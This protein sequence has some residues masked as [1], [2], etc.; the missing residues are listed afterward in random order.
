MGNVSLPFQY[1]VYGGGLRGYAGYA[2]D[3]EEN[4]IV[5]LNG[6]APTGLGVYHGTWMMAADLTTGQ[7]LWNRTYEETRYSTAAFVLTTD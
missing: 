1:A 7:M 4:V 6:I 5:V 2:V 3:Y